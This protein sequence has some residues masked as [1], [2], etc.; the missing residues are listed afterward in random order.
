MSYD[1]IP[2]DIME[3]V[4]EY[5]KKDQTNVSMHTLVKTGRQELERKPY[6]DE[7][8]TGSL[9]QHNA[10]GRVLIQVCRSP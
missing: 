5:G 10:S 8:I 3:L 4:Q 9:N 7:A 6:T 2:D 1:E